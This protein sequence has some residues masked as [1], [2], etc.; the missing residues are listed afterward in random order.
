MN[1]AMKSRETLNRFWVGVAAV[2]GLMLFSAC[3]NTTYRSEQITAG[4]SSYNPSV[5]TDSAVTVDDTLDANYTC[6][7]SA[8]TLPDYD[9]KNDGSG[10]Y[11]VCEKKDST[12]EILIHGK[13]SEY[14]AVCVFPVQVIDE[15]HIY[16]KPDVATGLPMVTCY[17]A[18]KRGV[19]AKF[20]GVRFNATFIVEYQYANAMRACLLSGNYY[21]CPNYSYGRF[22][23]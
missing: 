23:N 13:T 4:S 2:T 18:T 17:E 16:V 14:G 15:S 19:Y 20:A 5:S 7:Q 11:T 21:T 10:K 22:R 8:N 3:G 1:T 12:A 9:Y 6:P